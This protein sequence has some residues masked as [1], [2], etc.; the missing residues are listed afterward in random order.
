MKEDFIW[1]QKKF[2]KSEKEKTGFLDSRKK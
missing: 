2:K 1:L